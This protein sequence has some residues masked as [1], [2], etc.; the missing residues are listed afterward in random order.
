LNDFVELRQYAAIIL[1][2]WW[3]ILLGVVIGA[4]LGYGISQR[5]A[6]VYEATASLMV[7]Q[8]IQ[9]TNLNSQDI[10]T[11]ELL[12]LTYAEIAERQPVLQGTVEALELNVNWQQ[13]RKQVRVRPVDGTQLL[14][15]TVEA[16]SP[17]EAQ[18]I[19]NEIAHQLIL[20][21]PTAPQPQ[22]QASE[23][24]TLF[25]QQ[26]L[27]SLQDRIEKAQRRIGTLEDV[28]A[29]AVMAAEMEN[30]Q[31]EINTL[32]GLITSWEDNYA[33]LLSFVKDEK[34]ANY[35]AVIEEAQANPEP[36][37]PLVLLNIL[38]AAVVGLFLALGLVFTLE[39][40]DDSFKSTD[41]LNRI[42]NL[43]PLGAISRM[44]GKAH[45]DRLITSQ[46]FFSPVSEAYRMI[47]T[48]LQFMSVDRACK[49][50]MVTSAIPGEGK[51]TTVANLGIVMAHAGLETIIVDADLRRPTQSQIFQLHT[52]GGLT[53]LI[54]WP[55]LDIGAHLSKT[56]IE[57]LR[58]LASGPLPPNPSE[59]LGSRQMERLLAS[60]KEMA[61]VIILD[62]TPVISVTD[63]AVLSNRVD[64]V[65]LVV[66]AGQTRRDIVK[67]AIS[68]LQQAGANFLGA[69]LNG[70]SAKQGSY[71]HGHYYTTYN[72][73]EPDK[74][75]SSLRLAF[76]NRVKR[77]AIF[78]Q[79]SVRRESRLR[80]IESHSPD[81]NA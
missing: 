53:D 42:L 5:L 25:V 20:L 49:A 14:E 18:M 59:I 47:R 80:R 45:Q 9:A 23:G 2:R 38:L 48:N 64:G 58:V 81:A 36:V 75:P 17:Q 55:E 10:Q 71:Y 4:A 24:T 12:A 40:L 61:D 31:D 37:R 56:K 16:D 34:S 33:Q 65:V 54:R 6:P 21:S 66:R 52:Q 79:S 74:S 41:D 39:Y 1:R 78:K 63:A 60:L 68:L 35:L 69:V 43:V 72:E 73:G 19:A 7:G 50:I 62:S 76:V 44:T 57:R 51:S 29:T 28:M 15:V 27:D 11:S 26:R 22:N 77:L 13:L 70:L 46:G 3:I 67:P 30:L 8:S 32:E